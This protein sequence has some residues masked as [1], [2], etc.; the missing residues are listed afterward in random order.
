M[1][2]VLMREPAYVFNL[3]SNGERR[4]TK[5]GGAVFS[6]MQMA[7]KTD[8]ALA[9]RIRHLRFRSIEEY[10]NRRNDLG[11]LVNLLGSDRDRK[12]LNTT[13]KKN[14][15]AL[16]AKLREWMVRISDPALHAFDHRHQPETLESFMQDYR[17]RVAKEVEVLKPYKKRKSYRF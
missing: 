7:A 16:R 5:L 4:F 1:R 6:A 14:L 2:S 10:Y 8:A 12:S 3:W 11:C 17:T 15:D 9:G 13:E